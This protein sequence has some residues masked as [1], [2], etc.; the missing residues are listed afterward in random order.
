MNKVIS[1]LETLGQDAA[2]QRLDAATLNKVFNPL[3]T[4][5]QVQHA[6]LTRDHVQL[7]ALLQVRNKVVCAI[8]P[9]E[10]PPQDEPED[11]DETEQKSAVAAG[12]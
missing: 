9:P 1:L 3:D 10:E 2:L 6:I 11:D 8:C 4:D 12:F 5:I 7:E